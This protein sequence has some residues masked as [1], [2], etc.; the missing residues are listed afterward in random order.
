VVWFEGDNQ[1]YL[2]IW[3]TTKI[4]FKL[5]KIF[6]L[7]NP[8]G[9][10]IWLCISSYMSLKQNLI[11]I[12]MC[13]NNTNTYTCAHTHSH[14]HTQYITA[15]IKNSHF[16]DCGNW[17][18]FQTCTLSCFV[19]SWLYVTYIPFFISVHFQSLPGHVEVP[20]HW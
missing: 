20:I 15:P 5:H 11:N 14:A 16:V 2:Q 4:S 8:A 1:N 10:Y 19:Y 12:C 17:S 13:T 7:P 6:L 3:N 9:G 18:D